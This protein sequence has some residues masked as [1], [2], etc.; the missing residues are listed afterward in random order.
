M[1]RCCCFKDVTTHVLTHN[2][3]RPGTPPRPD[4]S[5]TLHLPV[6]QRAH[7]VVRLAIVSLEQQLARVLAQLD[8]AVDEQRA[9]GEDGEGKLCL[10]ATRRISKGEAFAMPPSSSSSDE[11]EK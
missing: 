3:A 8:A 4:G 5:N 10:V 1:R 7:R 11:E 6:Q 2:G 9:V